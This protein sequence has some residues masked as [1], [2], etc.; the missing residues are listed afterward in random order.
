MVQEKAKLERS[1]SQQKPLASPQPSAPTQKAV[2]GADIFGD[3]PSPPA[4]PS[5][6]DTPG[7]RPSPGKSSGAPKQPDSGNSLLG[8]DFFGGP[9]SVA[10]SKPSSISSPPVSSGPSRPD[11]KQSILSL[12]AAAP[13]TQ[14]QP[15]PQHERQ[16]S[17]GGMQS[18]PVQPSAAPQQSN[19]GGMNDAFSSLSF[20]STTSPP[21]PKA[22][23][24]AP[25]PFAAF[26]KPANQ[27]STIAAPQITSPH[28]S[29]GGFFDTS[30]KPAVKPNS[31]ANPPNKPAQA[32]LSFGVMD[33]SS[34]STNTSSQ[35]TTATRSNLNDLF[36]FSNPPK[37]EPTQKHAVPSPQTASAFNLS[38]PT[39]SSQAPTK[40]TATS[41]STNAF[42]NFSNVDPWGSSD[43]WATPE[44]SN[45]NN[46]A[47]TKTT[48]KPSITAPNDFS[49]WGS[50][51]PSIST[52]TAQ[53]PPK[54]AA[55][56]DF[57]GW[58][59]AAPAPSAMTKPPAS[60]G[61]KPAGG[62]G[63]GSEDLFSNVWE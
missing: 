9:P 54:I 19:F 58:N 7:T 1:S 52:S 14:S 23:Q 36:D 30:P 11:L 33:M 50:V 47:K 3:L 59:S 38:A 56:E 29:G 16:S 26:D 27:R 34:L 61:V 40:P 25:N 22:Q 62:Y 18:P 37:E 60:S 17:F 44:P 20:T 24:P 57:G 51:P 4:R 48:K 45:D 12:Y 55:D 15:Q 43:A 53:G 31:V 13:R 5:T 42:S 28:S 32:P 41:A 10:S 39:P 21:P 2:H 49:G 63:G 8:L 46:A 6:T 35:P